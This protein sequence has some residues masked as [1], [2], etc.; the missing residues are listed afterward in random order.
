MQPSKASSKTKN[1]A[2]AGQGGE[3]ER[4]QAREGVSK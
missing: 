3:R 4:E 1:L 2:V